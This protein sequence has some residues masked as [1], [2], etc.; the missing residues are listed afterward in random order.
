MGDI[1]MTRYTDLTLG[2][3]TCSRQGAVLGL[4]LVVVLVVTTLGSG[5]IAL[6]GANAVE[7]SKA[8]GA[9][10]SFWVA[11][12]GM[13]FA[14][15][16]TLKS[17]KPLPQIGSFSSGELSRSFGNRSFTITVSALGGYDNT[18]MR[19][20]RYIIT[21]T[22]VSPSGIA[23]Q[24][25]MEARL[26]TFACYLHASKYERTAD[27]TLAYFGGSDVLDGTVYVNDTLNVYGTPRFLS[28]TISAQS[29]VNYL[30]PVREGVDL[31]VFEGGLSLNARPLDFDSLSDDLSELKAMAL[32][33]GMLLDGTYRL[34]F[35]DS[36][37]AVCETQVAT[38]VITWEEATNIDL[39]TGNGII[40][41]SDD[42]Y[43]SGEVR[44]DITLVA[45]NSIFIDGDITYASASIKD[46]SVEGFD[47]LDITDTLGL[48]AGER[49]MVNTM[50]DVNIH[51]CILVMKNGFG[52]TL[53]DQ[54]LGNPSI[55]L[56]GG[57]TEYY[58]GALGQMGAVPLGF[59]KNYR[60]DQRILTNPPQGFPYNAYGFCDWHQL[61]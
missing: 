7:V 49:V 13:G 24:V 51:G 3:E 31:S 53:Y 11:E 44:G 57:I 43:I 33:G 27:G 15:A 45:E 50:S 48:I 35:H 41:V 20:Q 19:I 29:D 4:V 40:Y 30:S 8:I 28:K 37:L 34:A 26:D 12:A 38:A 55:N 36:G 23:R 2:D 42:V 25:A 60:Y 5:M 54:D 56:Y 14:K 18:N 59:S 47:N 9:A 6:S 46:H 10:E 22:A 1:E 39:S 32:S 58:R 17:R 21:S 52:A 61:R 16:I